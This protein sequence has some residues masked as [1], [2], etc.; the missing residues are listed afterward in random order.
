MSLQVPSCLLVRGDRGCK[1]FIRHRT[2]LSTRTSTDIIL[3]SG[4]RESF[5]IKKPIFSSLFSE[6]RDNQL[7]GSI[8]LKSSLIECHYPIL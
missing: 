1:A 7:S 6:L 3:K 4:P 2:S 5:V 8:W